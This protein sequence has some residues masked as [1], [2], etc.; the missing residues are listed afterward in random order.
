[1]GKRDTFWDTLPTT[2]EGN[3]IWPEDPEARA[4]LAR[5]LLGCR[6]VGALE[7]VLDDQLEVVASA[8][9]TPGSEGFQIELA[10]RAVFAE[11]TP[12]QRAEVTRLVKRACFGT[13]YWIMVRL[14]HY[15]GGDVDFRVSPYTAE[16]AALPDIDVTETE[17][18]HHY[19]RWVEKFA[20]HDDGSGAA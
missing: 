12:L 16:G 20:D 11:L 3:I 9:P 18:F 5:D 14:R 1:M 15:P 10:R 6:I 19:H 7:S 17:L 8:P 13:L 4:A 2:S